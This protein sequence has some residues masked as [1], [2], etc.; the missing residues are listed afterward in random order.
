[1]YLILNMKLAAVYDSWKEVH[2]EQLRLSR[3]KR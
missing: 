2:E 3:I 1:V